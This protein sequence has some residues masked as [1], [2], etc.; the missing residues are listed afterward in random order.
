MSFILLVFKNVLRN[1]IRTTLTIAGISIGIAAIIIFG[2]VTNG[3][4]SSLMSAFSPGQADF[5]VA[6]ADIADMILSVITKDQVQTIKS[7]EGVDK[8]VPYILSLSAFEKNPYFWMSGI[9]PKDL[10][11]LGITVSEGRIYQNNDEIVIGRLASKT[12]NLTIGNTISINGKA[13]KIVGIF[14]SGITMQDSGAAIMLEEAQHLNSLKEDQVSM[15]LVKVKKGYTPR[16]VADNIEQK[17]PSLIGIVDVGDYSSID[18]G[19]TIIDSISVV[20]SA[21]ALFIGGISVMNTIIMSVFERT[22]E[23][24]VLRAIGWKRRRIMGMILCEAL[25]L[26]LLATIVGTIL[27]LFVVWLTMQTNLGKSWLDITWEIGI[28][29]QAIIVALCVVM[30]GAA[31]PA[32]RASRFSPIE[33]LRYE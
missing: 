15:A 30:L 29:T 8:V 27:G 6:K 1:R 13:Y 5:T 22:R 11:S 14:E 20:I 9:D 28:F 7:V 18:Q 25:L 2:M 21:L 3:F 31:Y 26:A 33:A 12:Y 16:S 24:G 10:D 17:D 4:K 32:Y 23:I 19:F